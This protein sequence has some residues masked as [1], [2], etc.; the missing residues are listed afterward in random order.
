MKVV[1]TTCFKYCSY[2]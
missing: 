1:E 2:I